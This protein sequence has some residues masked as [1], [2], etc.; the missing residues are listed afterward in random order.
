[1]LNTRESFGQNNFGVTTGNIQMYK[2]HIAVHFWKMRSIVI[3]HSYIQFNCDLQQ[4]TF[5]TKKTFKKYWIQVKPSQT[6][7]IILY[8]TMDS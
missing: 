3:R 1:M 6:I 2:N 4:Y 7:T 5:T 8:C